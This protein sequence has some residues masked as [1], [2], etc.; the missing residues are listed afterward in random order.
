MFIS[1]KTRTLVRREVGLATI[2]GIW[3]GQIKVIFRTW[4]LSI[5][6]RFQKDPFSFSSKARRSICVHTTVLMRFRLSTLQSS[7]TIDL[8][9]V[10]QVE[11]YVHVTNTRAYDILQPSWYIWRHRFHFDAFSTVRIDTIC[12]RF[13]FDLLSRAFSNQ[14]NERHGYIITQESVIKYGIPHRQET[15]P[16]INS[17]STVCNQTSITRF[18]LP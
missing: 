7:K 5:L 10:T 1:V 2:Q 11:H 4:T 13:R 18:E 6:M 8:H 17:W 9:V 16:A 14:I 3:S 15:A 12:M